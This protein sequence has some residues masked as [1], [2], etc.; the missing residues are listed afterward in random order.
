M[1]ATTTKRMAT[2]VVEGW[3]DPRRR[4]VIQTRKE[5]YKSKRI[6]VII[7]SLAVVFFVFIIRA[8]KYSRVRACVCRLLNK[9]A[10]CCCMSTEH[11]DSVC[12]LVVLFSL[13]RFFFSFILLA[14]IY[15]LRLVEHWRGS[16]IRATILQHRE[17]CAKHLRQY[18]GM[19]V[20][21]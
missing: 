8:Y 6:T 12:V 9:F 3:R 18:G 7:T 19:Y 2:E 17:P 11:T 21:T 1:T 4:G 5:S 20:T 13:F 14:T 10:V 15:S 16:H